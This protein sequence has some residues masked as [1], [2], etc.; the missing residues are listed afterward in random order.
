[1]NAASYRITIEIDDAD[2]KLG[3]VQEARSFAA[4]VGAGAGAQWDE[5]FT[6]GVKVIEVERVEVEPR[7]SYEARRRRLGEEAL[8]QIQHISYD[9]AILGDVARADE[10]TEG[11]SVD[12]VGALTTRLQ[13]ICDIAEGCEPDESWEPLIED[14]NGDIIAGG[15]RITAG[16]ASIEPVS[17]PDR[18]EPSPQVTE[19]YILDVEERDDGL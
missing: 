17:M 6:P 13:R 2:G 5:Q 8:T 19:I 11:N 15:D 16:V 1:M 10:P 12:T 18:T 3:R 14:N 4:T 9:A 7:Q